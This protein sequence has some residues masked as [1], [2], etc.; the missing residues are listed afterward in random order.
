MSDPRLNKLVGSYYMSSYAEYKTKAD[1]KLQYVVHEAWKALLSSVDAHSTAEL[2]AMIGAKLGTKMLTSL[3]G[4]IPI[5]VVSDV[6]A[7]GV[8]AAAGLVTK[9]IQ[10]RIATEATDLK[11]IPGVAG[12]AV[13]YATLDKV[14]EAM[15]GLKASLP[16]LKSS[17]EEYQ[18]QLEQAPTLAKA[19]PEEI[20]KYLHQLFLHWH[21]VYFVSVEVLKVVDGVEG[22]FGALNALLTKTAKEFVGPQSEALQTA[23]IEMLEPA[24][25]PA[26]K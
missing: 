11:N 14:E 3:A 4:K 12:A 1:S 6:V 23:V 19:S 13:D 5:P 22:A 21:H 16:V 25:Q 9:K 8:G 7:W 26:K 24:L 17:Y 20:K 10:E 2:P 15:K 18:K